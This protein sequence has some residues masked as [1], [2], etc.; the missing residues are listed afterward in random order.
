MKILKAHAWHINNKLFYAVSLAA[1]AATAKHGVYCSPINSRINWGSNKGDSSQQNGL[2]KGCVITKNMYCSVLINGSVI[3]IRVPYAYH[4]TAA[5]GG[6]EEKQDLPV[7]GRSC[8]R[9][10]SYAYF[11]VFLRGRMAIAAAPVIR[12]TAAQ[13][14]TLVSSPVFGLLFLLL[15]LLLLVLLLL[16]LLPASSTF[17]VRS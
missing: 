9:L 4:E 17:S 12:S 10:V 3:T 15:L 8:I 13:I 5:Q 1:G 16:S 6:G 11:W 2:K 14:V 7:F